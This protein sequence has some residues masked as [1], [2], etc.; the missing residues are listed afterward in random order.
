MLGISDFMADVETP[1]APSPAAEPAK[2]ETPKA[3]ETVSV[4]TNAEDYAKWRKT[5]ELPKEP[6]TE[7][8]ATSKKSSVTPDS[9]PG[10]HKRQGNADT[11]KQELNEEIRGLI[12][13]RDELKREIEG[14]PEKKDVKRE[15]STAQPAQP[16]PAKRPVK[17]KQ[18]DF[19]TWDEYDAALDKYHE[20]LSDFKANERLQK[21]IQ[22]TQQAAQAQAMQVKLDEAK[23]RY[24]EEAEPKILST[25][26]TVFEDQ[27]VAPAIKTAIGRSNVMVDALYVM[28][29]DQNELTAFIDLAVKDPLEALRKW[30]TV[31]ALVSAELGKSGKNGKPESSDENPPRGEDGKFVSAATKPPAKTQKT[32][33]APPTELGANSSPPGDDR[34]R[35][36]A[37]GDVRA[38]FREGNRRDIAR[39]KGNA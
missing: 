37:S 26:R 12:A 20:D 10:A 9:E 35:A 25:A 5:G 36:A 23:S 39:W 28:G 19:K 38:F 27:K 21:H 11:R 13:R 34:D 16:E 30:Y 17:P 15:S 22:E 33:P 32:A 1:A 24:G 3:A 8:S 31:E 14:P 29:S 6:S 18:E 7:D 4:P 2:Q